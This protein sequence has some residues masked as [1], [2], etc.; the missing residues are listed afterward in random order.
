[1]VSWTL[2]I[3]T[4]FKSTKKHNAQLNDWSEA[5]VQVKRLDADVILVET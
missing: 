3:I 5:T 2:S 1:M 4:L